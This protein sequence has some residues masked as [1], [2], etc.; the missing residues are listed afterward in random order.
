[1]LLLLKSNLPTPA[2]A[3][4]RPLEEAFLKSFVAMYGTEG[5]VEAIWN[6]TYCTEFEL[7]GKQIDE[8]LGTEP[9]FE[10]T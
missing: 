2:F 9:R 3:L 7:V 4:L 5:Q 6:G 8:M 10:R 1:M